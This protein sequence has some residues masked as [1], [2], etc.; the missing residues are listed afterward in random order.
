MPGTIENL[1]DQVHEAFEGVDCILHAGDLHV[2]A[3]IEEL[4]TIAPTFVCMGNGDMDVVH[5]R[6]K[7]TWTGAFAD[8]KIGMVHQFPTPRRGNSSR[9]EKKLTK[10]FD[11][12]DP[13]IVVYGHTHLAELHTLENRLYINPGSATLPNNQ[14]TRMGTL[15]C[16]EVAQNSA[17]VVLWQL[18]DNGVHPI[19]EMQYTA[20]T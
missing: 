11:D 20:I 5:P 8:L 7:E 1:W 16:L 18:S 10:H 6:L 19:E 4:E 2:A 14:S 17:Q 3:V 15:G 13:H 12:Y 9:L